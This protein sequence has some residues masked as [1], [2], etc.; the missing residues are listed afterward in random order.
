MFLCNYTFSRACHI[1]YHCFLMNS[2][3]KTNAKWRGLFFVQ[4]QTRW[5]KA[6]R[7][8]PGSREPVKETDRRKLRQ[9]LHFVRKHVI[10]ALANFKTNLILYPIFFPS[11]QLKKKILKKQDYYN[12]NKCFTFR[13]HFKFKC[14]VDVVLQEAAAH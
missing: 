9:G 3:S 6:Q 14:Y 10:Q 11:P 5:H 8:K 12:K 7:R 2:S 4:L 1:W 13:K